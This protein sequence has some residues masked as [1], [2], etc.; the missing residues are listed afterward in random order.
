MQEEMNSDMGNANKIIQKKKSLSFAETFSISAASKFH[1][2]TN[3][4]D[5]AMNSMKKICAEKMI[6]YLCLIK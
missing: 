1:N 4:F 6:I 2:T 5:Y 3:S